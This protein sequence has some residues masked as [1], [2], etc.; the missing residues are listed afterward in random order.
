MSEAELKGA[1]D[2]FAHSSKIGEGGFG[3]VYKAYFRCTFVAIK[4]LSTVSVQTTVIC[5]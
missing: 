4:V 2:N 5:A 1:T 3:I